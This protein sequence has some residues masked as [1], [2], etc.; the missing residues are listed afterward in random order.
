M[1]DIN[2]LRLNRDIDYA[3]CARGISKTKLPNATSNGRHGLPIERFQ[4]ALNTVK[5]KT[6]IPTNICGKIFQI[7]KR[8]SQKCH[9]LHLILL[10]SISV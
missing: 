9:G 1:Q 3:V 10:I 8:V 2:R 6:G 5:L 4:A 7:G